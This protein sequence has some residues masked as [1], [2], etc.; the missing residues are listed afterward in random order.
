MLC[1]IVEYGGGV[2]CYFGFKGVDRILMCY[3]FSTRQLFIL[4]IRGSVSL[5]S[6]GGDKD[7]Q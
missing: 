3:H 4:F 2:M 7:F 6:M 5:E 1:R